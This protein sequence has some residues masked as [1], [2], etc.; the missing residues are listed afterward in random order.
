MNEGGER[1]GKMK[2]DAQIAG[3]LVFTYT[4]KQEPLEK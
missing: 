2:R 3:W 4:T 1:V